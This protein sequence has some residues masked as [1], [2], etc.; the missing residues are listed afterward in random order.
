MRENKIYFHGSFSVAGCLITTGY[1]KKW[2]ILKIISLGYSFSS[3]SSASH[4]MGNE[5]PAE[6]VQKTYNIQHCGCKNAFP[7][8]SIWKFSGFGVY[9]IFGQADFIGAY[10]FK[11][12]PKQLAKQKEPFWFVYGSLGT[13]VCNQP[14]TLQVIIPL[15]VRFPLPSRARMHRMHIWC[16]I[17]H[18]SSK[19][20]S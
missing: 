14:E 13:L 19:V 6:N 15:D 4:L 11:G 18:T 17:L 20:L 12:C 5:P 1:P 10:C 9:L 3:C 2:M 8:E 7:S 16:C